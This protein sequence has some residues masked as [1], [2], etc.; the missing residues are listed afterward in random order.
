MKFLQNNFHFVLKPYLIDKDTTN[1]PGLCSNFES[2]LA[3]RKNAF[4]VAREREGPWCARMVIRCDLAAARSG[5]TGS[6]RS[7][8]GGRRWARPDCGGAGG[9]RW[10]LGLAVRWS[11]E[12]CGAGGAGLSIGW[13]SD[14]AESWASGGCERCAGLEEKEGGVLICDVLL[15]L[16]SVTQ[17]QSSEFRAHALL[18]ASLSDH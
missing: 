13:R 17:V 5:F 14:H 4:R 12:A 1:L 10:W 16:L 3:K 15:P 18:Q 8:A 11:G 2:F 6:T 9:V 7:R